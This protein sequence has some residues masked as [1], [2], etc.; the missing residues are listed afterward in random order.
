MTRVQPP[1]I[2]HITSM[3][4]MAAATAKKNEARESSQDSLYWRES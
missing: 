1:L 2:A 4:T 3:E